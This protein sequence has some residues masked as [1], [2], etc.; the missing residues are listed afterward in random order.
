M[1]FQARCF[2]RDWRSIT[3][4]E[5]VA[6]SPRARNHWRFS[7]G[8]FFLGVTG[9]AIL[10]AVLPYPNVAFYSLLALFF[11]AAVVARFGPLNG[12]Q[13]WFWFSLCGWAYILLGSFV[14][15]AVEAG[16]QTNVWD[17]LK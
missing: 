8:T 4:T 13:F 16:I 7:L 1:Q 10:C 12:R 15:E 2:P 6:L 11:L 9:A 5:G 17:W 3:R 14:L